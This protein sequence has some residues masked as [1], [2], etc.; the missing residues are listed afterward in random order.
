MIAELIDKLKQHGEEI[1]YDPKEMPIEYALENGELEDVKRE[2]NNLYIKYKNLEEICNTLRDSGT[3]NEMKVVQL[4]DAIV[5]LVKD[6]DEETQ[7]LKQALQ[8]NQI[9]DVK[10]LTNKINELQEKYNKSKSDNDV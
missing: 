8:T 7:T 9:S 3:E 10:G 5:K 4:K 6:H 1:D 2:L